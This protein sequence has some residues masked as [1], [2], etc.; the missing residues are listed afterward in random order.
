[1]SGGSGA[2][3]VR[4]A[5][6]AVWMWMGRRGRRGRRSARKR[7]RSAGRIVLGLMAGQGGGGTRWLVG[8]SIAGTME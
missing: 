3:V 2:R 8:D 4:A 7:T 5:R 6:L 1:M